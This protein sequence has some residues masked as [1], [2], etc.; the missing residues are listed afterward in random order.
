MNIV[1]SIDNNYVQHCG[2]MLTSL[3]ENN[4]GEQVTIY[5]LS[6]DLADR[7]IQSLKA[8]VEKYNSTFCYCKIDK[9]SMADC[10]IRKEDH[11][12]IATYY[13]LLIP[14]VLPQTETKAIYL[15]CDIIV[16]GS[17]RPL[18]ESD[19]SGFA[20]AAVEERKCHAT[21]TFLRLRY[22]EQYGYFNAGVLLFNL[23]YWRSHDTV[24]Q[25]FS[26]IAQNKN[27]L[28]Y[29]DQDTLNATLHDKWLHLSCKW[30][31]EEAFFRYDIVQRNI[32]SLDFMSSLKAPQILHFTWKPKPWEP[33]CFH[34]LRHVYFDYLKLT[35]WRE[36]Q[37]GHN[38]IEELKYIIKKVLAVL[39]I[40]S[41]IYYHL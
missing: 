15:D 34:P 17:L 13:R 7:G 27:I 38:R 11:L 1:C 37:V 26:F 18:W 21:D 28:T 35:E 4:K 19:L 20:L 24:N 33:A 36:Y 14:S 40:K 10:P 29:H 23:D 31:M 32:D 41:P 2:I 12:S 5:L 22:D 16:N 9:D 30:N 39:R 8:I 6:E 25:C 3:F